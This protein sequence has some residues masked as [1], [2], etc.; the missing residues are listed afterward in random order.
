MLMSSLSRN[1]RPEIPVL[2]DRRPVPILKQMPYSPVSTVEG[3]GVASQQPLHCAREKH[4]R[5]SHE[6]MEVV[7]NERPRVDEERF[8]LDQSDEA[9]NETVPILVV[10]EDLDPLDPPRPHMMQDTGSIESCLPCHRTSPQPPP[11]HT[12]A[13][14]GVTTAS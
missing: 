11:G 2:A 3:S 7:G 8:S 6:K 13:N 5:G 1:T 9:V 4:L 14:K 10:T 12:P